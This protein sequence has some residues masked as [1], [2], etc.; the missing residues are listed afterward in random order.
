MTD[1][2]AISYFTRYHDLIRFLLLCVCVLNLENN[3]LFNPEKFSE[4]IMTLRSFHI[5]TDMEWLSCGLIG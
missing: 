1:F 2:V 5:I 3:F 4:V